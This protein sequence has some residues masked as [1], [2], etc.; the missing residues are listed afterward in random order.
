[1]HT[2]IIYN[3][4]L[5][6]A[7]RGRA[8]VVSPLA[9]YGRGVFTTLAV[10][11][12][13]PFL[14]PAHWER[15]TAHAKRIGLDLASLAAEQV[16]DALLRLIEANAVER[17]RARVT[18]APSALAVGGPWSPEV[19]PAKRAAIDFM[20]FTGE[21]RAVPA[22]GLALTVSPFRASTLGPLAGVK[23]VN[24]LEHVLAW[25][26]ARARKFDEAVILNERGEIVSATMANLFWIVEGTLHTPALTTGCIAGTTRACVIEIAARLSIP[27]V[28]G[29]YDLARL[30]EADE[31]FLTSSG[32]GVAPV[33]AFDFRRYT[34][35]AGSLA[36]RIGEAFRQLTLH[37]EES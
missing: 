19:A 3:N 36:L 5:V 10:Y 22:E 26:E 32:I 2:R 11:H 9:V 8:P 25:E 7:A 33:T 16:R 35:P 27:F 30:G 13:Q 12:G 28:E 18:V 15:L 24:Y 37:A 14:W 23:S 4:R 29:V 6:E 1:M 21:W 34:L 17:G 20:I 31:V